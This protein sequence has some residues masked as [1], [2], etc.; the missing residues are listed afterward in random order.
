MV[1]TLRPQI[2]IA[3]GLEYSRVDIPAKTKEREWGLLV[4]KI[5]YKLRLGKE[6]R[7]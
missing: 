4:T 3:N 5:D 6:V 7:V 1:V 2:N